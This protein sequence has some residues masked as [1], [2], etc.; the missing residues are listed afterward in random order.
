[1]PINAFTFQFCGLTM[2]TLTSYEEE[3]PTGTTMANQNLKELVQ[4]YV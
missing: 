1:M 4:I 3:D 2:R